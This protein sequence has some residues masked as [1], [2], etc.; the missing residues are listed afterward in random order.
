MSGAVELG[1]QLRTLA[2]ARVFF[3]HQSVGGNIL[4]GLA[5]LGREAGAGLQ[6]V[7]LASGAA[8]PAL[9]HAF[10]GDNGRPDAKLA[11]FGAAL[12]GLSHAPPEVA[13]MKFCYLD[14]TPDTDVEALL[15][16]YRATFD[17][18]ARR[19]P[20]VL[21]L[22]AT[23]PLTTRP[24]GPKARAWRLIGRR[25]WQDAANQR[26]HLFNQRL[27]ANVP[28]QALFDLARVEATR[29]DGSPEWFRIGGSDCPALCP[30]YAEGDGHLN[31]TG[32][33]RVA[34][35]LARVLAAALAAKRRGS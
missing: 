13:L 26:R 20:G 34:P 6:I 33:R 27:R 2:G 7:P 12:D 5:R 35:E 16:R 22:H 24:T 28:E 31:E 9:L 8:G 17:A 10:G 23:V 11:F 32:R 25:V 14:F 19:H 15:D 4:D 1:A 18:V 29:P 3:S 30:G 21:L